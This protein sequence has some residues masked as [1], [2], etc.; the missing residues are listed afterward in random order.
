MAW[1][2]MH[3]VMSPVYST[4][5]VWMPCQAL[6]V[7]TADFDLKIFLLILTLK[8]ALIKVKIHYDPKRL[9]IHVVILL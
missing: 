7:I 2:V 3:N 8:L 6:R 9:I 5:I 4:L 1:G